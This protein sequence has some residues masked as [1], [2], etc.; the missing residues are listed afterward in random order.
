MIGSTGLDPSIEKAVFGTLAPGLPVAALTLPSTDPEA[1]ALTEP[2]AD[3]EADPEADADADPEADALWDPDADPEALADA[4]WLEVV[5]ASVKIAS[6]LWQTSLSSTHTTWVVSLGRSNPG[7]GVISVTV[8]FTVKGR[9]VRQIAPSLS[10]VNVPRTDPLISTLNTAP[11]RCWYGLT[12]FR[13]RIR[14]LAPSGAS[15]QCESWSLSLLSPGPVNVTQTCVWS[16][17]TGPAESA[18]QEPWPDWVML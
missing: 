12:A 10:V 17:G 14:R 13:F 1:A 6:A 16:E 5:G 9:P 18:D 3:P 7:G 4:D 11:A 15:R 2:S 8:A